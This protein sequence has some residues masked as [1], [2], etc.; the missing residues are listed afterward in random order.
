MRREEPG[1]E[2]EWGELWGRRSALAFPRPRRTGRRGTWGHRAARAQ[3]DGWTASVPGQRGGNDGQIPADMPKPWVPLVR[4][5][6]V[7]ARV[8]GGAV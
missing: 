8:A 1:D 4:K 3:A 2:K 5:S 6:Q 7:Y